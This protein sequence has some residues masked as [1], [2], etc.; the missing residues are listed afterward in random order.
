M[1]DSGVGGLTVAVRVRELLPAADI[2]YVADQGRAPYGPRPLDEVRG[3]AVEVAGRLIDEGAGIVV[4][5]CNTASAAALHHLRALHPEVPFVGMEPAVKPA[6]A[7]SRSGTIGVLATAATF[8]GELFASVVDRHARD[9]RVVAEACTGW[10]ELVERGVIDGPEAEA[11]VRAHL[12]P[13]LD[14]GADALVLGCTHFPFLGPV[15][16]AVAG[17]GVGLVDPSEAVARRVAELAGPA[18][19]GSGRFSA[20][21]TGDPASFDRTVARLVGLGLRSR[22]WGPLPSPA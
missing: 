10:V 20:V 17:E 8:Q 6:A 21:T 13:V 22:P 5:A 18:G 4:V 1:F 16:R 11:A 12:R 15:I 19:H 14:A 3:Y 9:V 2:L 7:L